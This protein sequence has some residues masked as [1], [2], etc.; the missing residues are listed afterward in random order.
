MNIVHSLNVCVMSCREWDMRGNQIICR[1][2][3]KTIQANAEADECPHP[4]G[5]KFES[6]GVGDTVAKIIQ[7]VTKKAPCGGCAK[8]RAALNKILPYKK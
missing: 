7:T 6:R 1:A 5:R 8:R 2:N 4:T 3:G